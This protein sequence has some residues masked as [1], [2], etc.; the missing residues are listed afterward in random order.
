MLLLNLLSK[1]KSSAKLWRDKSNQKQKKIKK[2]EKRMKELLTSRDKWKMKHKKLQ[3]EH[4]ELKK[5]AEC[6]E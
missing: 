1:T 6:L 5:N 2:M 3:S 4:E